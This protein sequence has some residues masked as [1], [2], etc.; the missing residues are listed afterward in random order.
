[1]AK[2]C[3]ISP[4][5]KV[6]VWERDNHKCIFCGQL[7]LVSCAC[8]HFVPRSQGGLGIEQNILTACP[9]CHRE[10]DN[11]LHTAEYDKKAEAYLRQIYGKDWT[12]EK[13]IYKKRRRNKWK[14]TN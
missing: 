10:M 9:D 5:T 13:L 2:A 7:V 11:G 3:D 1:M 8:C 12:K 6:N 14:I 4:S